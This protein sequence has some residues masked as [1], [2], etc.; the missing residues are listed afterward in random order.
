MEQL[1]NRPVYAYA[2]LEEN[3]CS[4]CDVSELPDAAQLSSNSKL[5]DPFIK[6]DGTHISKKSE[7]HCRRQEIIM[8]AQKYIYGE[9]PMPEIV[10]GTVTE[11]KFLLQ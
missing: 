1:V 6:I 2:A 9:K 7:W 5:P 11:K 3:T 8:Q 10:T 4:D